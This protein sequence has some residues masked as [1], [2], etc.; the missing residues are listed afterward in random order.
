MKTLKHNLSMLLQL[1]G[2]LIAEYIYVIAE[3]TKILFRKENI[4]FQIFS[5]SVLLTS[6]I[7]L[8]EDLVLG[9][10]FAIAGY[11]CATYYNWRSKDDLRVYTVTVISLALISSFG[12]YKW[13]EG[14]K[15]ILVFEYFIFIVTIIL[16][17]IVYRLTKKKIKEASK[18]T[19]RAKRNNPK[20]QFIGTIWYMF[21]L[22][23]IGYIVPEGGL[24]LSFVDWTAGETPFKL[25][26]WI[27]LFFGNFI[28]MRVYWVSKDYFFS[29]LQIPSAI[30]S[31]LKVIEM[32]Q[33]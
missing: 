25:L 13:A 4:T 21:C 5:A 30:I 29:L 7:L 31:L 6:K 32:I 24:A 17:S 28:S 15:Q 11:L 33:G 14:V 10:I 27:M 8:K 1:L 19:S 16:A 9:W 12:L 22:P 20:L 2:L 23:F 26:G 18:E 3:E